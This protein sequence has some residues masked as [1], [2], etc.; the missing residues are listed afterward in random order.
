DFKKIDIDFVIG[1][2]L[3]YKLPCGDLLRL[4]TGVNL[5]F[6]DYTS[7]Y[8]AYHFH[9]TYGTFS[10]RHNFLYAQFSYIHTFNYEKAK[11]RIK[12]N[13][14]SF[15]SKKERRSYIYDLLK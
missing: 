3:Y 5:A 15:D 14:M 11:I 1:A 6:K 13:N 2:G 8:Y 4:T 12:R 7:G 9:D 10:V